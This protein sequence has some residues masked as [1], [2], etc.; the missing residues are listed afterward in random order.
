V[1]TI[2]VGKKKKERLPAEVEELKARAAGMAFATR[3]RARRFKDRKKDADR[4]ACRGNEAKNHD[5]D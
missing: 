3:G 2:D 1:Y 5:N 4:K